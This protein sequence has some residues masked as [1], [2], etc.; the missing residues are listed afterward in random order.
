[1]RRVALLPLAVVAASP[2]AHAGAE[3]PAEAARAAAVG[4]N[5]FTADVLR[6]TAA[7][8]GNSFLSPYSISVAMA[9]ARAG[10][11]GATAAEMDAALH[12]PPDG[13]AAFRALVA[14]LRDVPM[15]TEHVAGDGGRVERTTSPAYALSVANG[16]FSQRGWAFEPAYRSTIGADY[17]AELAEVDFKDGE[18]ARKTINDWVAQKT[19]DRIKDI[20]PAGLPTPDTRMALA[21]AIHFKA[22][23]A[24]PFP[25]RMTA[26]KPFTV[27]AGKEVQAKTMS[28]TRSMA[29]GEHVD[30]QVLEI[31]YR[32]RATSMVVVLP[33]AKDGLDALVAGLTPQRLESLLGTLA[34]RKVALELPKF[35]FTTAFDAAGALGALGIKAAFSPTADFSGI[36]RSQP[37]FIGPVLHKAF[38]AV[39][40]KG[41]EAA[42]ATVVMMRAG[43][44]PRPDEPTPFVVDHPFLFV[45]RHVPTGTILFAGRVVDPTTS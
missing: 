25:E 43:S 13:P 32:D 8:G 10:A 11:R 27:A 16:L 30:A 38:V 5:A 14:A 6:T 9:M 36:T 19:K 15:T 24:E 20:V 29:Y 45:I 3:A 17:G 34:H 35:S 4:V 18:A 22:S 28:I 37:L 41:T 23:W 7:S 2:L 40:E 21:N 42:A 33:R 44:A 31:S 26:D 1:M 39:D 12:L